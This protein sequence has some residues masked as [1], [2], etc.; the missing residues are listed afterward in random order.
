MC[1]LSK[2][3]TCAIVF[4]LT[5]CS[6]FANSQTVVE[7]VEAAPNA[8]VAASKVP[9][10]TATPSPGKDRSKLRIGAGD[11]LDVSI[12]GV[13]DF[14][15]EAR[16]NESGDIDL[17]L[18]GGEHVGGSGVEEAQTMI[19]KS[20][21]DGG[22]YRDPHVTVLIKEFSSERVSILGEITKPGMYPIVG[23]RTLLDLVSE[24]GGFTAKAGDEITI[25]HRDEPNDPR[26][27][28]LSTEP[29][30]AMTGNVEIDPGDTVVVAKAG[31][32][33]VVG[34]V[35]RPGGFVMENNAPMTV[36]Q[37]IAMASGTNR[38]AALNSARI[39]RRTPAGLTEVKIPLKQ[40]LA[41]KTT[42]MPMYAEDIL[43]IPGS[44][45]RSVMTRS[46]ES[47]FQIATS[48]AIYGAHF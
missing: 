16:V 34:D 5:A 29:G 43:F 38:T 28:K 11:L 33:Y 31:I 23:T 25:T 19:A 45:A 12:Y 10:V 21:V 9:A 26:T 3:R 32:V 41:A 24:A 13:S 47:V 15:Q 42:D 6:C 18:I 40:I 37:A 20:L 7:P 17:P 1:D 39:V 14:H 48:A 30:K 36:L 27:V 2:L 8:T 46:M 44:A 4:V 22:Y 35:G